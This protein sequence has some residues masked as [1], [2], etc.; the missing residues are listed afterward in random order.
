MDC[1]FCHSELSHIDGALVCT[2]CGS[3]TNLFIYTPSTDHIQRPCYKRSNH[4]KKVLSRY[5]NLKQSEVHI[6]QTHFH[7]LQRAFERRRG[8]RRNMLPYQFVLYKLC[9]YL[10][11][12]HLLPLFHISKSHSKLEEQTGLWDAICKDLRWK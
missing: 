6:L 1:Y 5:P 12:T 3:T 9:Q 10:E 7:Q 4:M 2:E 8:K 11:L